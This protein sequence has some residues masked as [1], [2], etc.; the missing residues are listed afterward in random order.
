MRERRSSRSSSRS[1]MMRGAECAFVKAKAA[2]GSNQS[3]MAPHIPLQRREYRGYLR[4]KED[5]GG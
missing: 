3:V 1:R 5:E 2:R 4:K